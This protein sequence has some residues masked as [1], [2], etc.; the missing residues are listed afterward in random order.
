MKSRALKQS[1]EFSIT[2]NLSRQYS[3]LL[4]NTYSSILNTKPVMKHLFRRESNT[5]FIYKPIVLFSLSVATFWLPDR[6]QTGVISAYVGK[7]C[8]CFHERNAI[9]TNYCGS[10]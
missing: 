3:S 10:D 2:S 7:A 9:N 4:P 6:Q 1:F 5:D 8:C